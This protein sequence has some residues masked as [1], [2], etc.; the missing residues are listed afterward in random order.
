MRVPLCVNVYMYIYSPISSQSFLFLILSLVCFRIQSTL[1]SCPFFPFFYCAL[2]FLPLLLI[3]GLYTCLP[4]IQ[5]FNLLLGP[6]NWLSIC[7]CVI[8]ASQ[9]KIV[10]FM[11]HSISF[12]NLFLPLPSF[13]IWNLHT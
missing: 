9:P 7:I 4:Y 13:F 2:S 6:I 1:I 10:P 3:H 5:I 12:L 8:Y 11:C